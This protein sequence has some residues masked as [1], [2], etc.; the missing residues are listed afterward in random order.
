MTVRALEEGRAAMTYEVGNG[1]LVNGISDVSS[2]QNHKIKG[3]INYTVSTL[4]EMLGE[5]RN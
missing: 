2:P 3:A 4:R 5:I 1:L